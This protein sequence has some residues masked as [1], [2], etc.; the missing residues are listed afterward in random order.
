MAIRKMA[1]KKGKGEN[2]EV[3]DSLGY[4][5]DGDREA[6]DGAGCGLAANDPFGH[7]PVEQP[8][9]G[10]ERGL[11]RFAVAFREQRFQAP[12]RRPH[13]RTEMAVLHRLLDS[14]AVSLLC[15]Q[16]VCHVFSSVIPG[17]KAVSQGIFRV[18]PIPLD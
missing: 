8:D 7:R 4:L 18:K 10:P 9:G 17:R 2:A 13:G 5:V 12:D 6:G 3:A 14:L 11:A 16:V 1:P 15:L